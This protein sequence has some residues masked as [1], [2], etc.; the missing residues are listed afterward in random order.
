MTWII[1]D[2]L[3]GDFFIIAVVAM[4]I[5]R[6]QT[7]VE[8][9]LVGDDSIVGGGFPVGASCWRLLWLKPHTRHYLSYSLKYAQ[10]QKMC[11]DAAV[12]AI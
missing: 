10:T 4:S 12:R 1:P 7:R 2:P 6:R 9:A 5:W 11:Y 3:G 8:V